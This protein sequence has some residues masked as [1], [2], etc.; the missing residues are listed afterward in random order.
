MKKKKQQDLKQLDRYYIG[1]PETFRRVRR[2]GCS[3]ATCR[4]ILRKYEKQGLIA[5]HDMPM[6]RGQRFY[7]MTKKGCRAIGVTSKYTYA[8]KFRVQSFYILYGRLCYC[9]NDVDESGQETKQ[10]LKPSDFEARF[11]ELA[12]EPVAKRKFFAI[13]SKSNNLLA[14]HVIQLPDVR[15]LVTN[16]NTKFTRYIE[17]ELFRQLI[18]AGRFKMVLILPSVGMKE[19]LEA[20]LK[21]RAIKLERNAEAKEQDI[22][23][24][25]LLT[26]TLEL[27]PSPELG[28]LIG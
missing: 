20:E 7:F 19:S 12:S 8:A 17:S 16:T 27:W 26:H 1:T 10:L 14:L 25:K 15:R 18:I 6:H 22:A 9:S 21:L 5:S 24:L 3:L 28:R 13:D 11:P 23:F 2:P 4:G